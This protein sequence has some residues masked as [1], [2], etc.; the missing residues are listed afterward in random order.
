VIHVADIHVPFLKQHLDVP[1]AEERYEQF[2]HAIDGLVDAVRSA[3]KEQR[4]VTVAVVVGDVLDCRHTANAATVALVHR[5]IEGLARSVPVYVTAGNHDLLLDHDGREGQEDDLLGV[6]LAPL[7]RRLPVAYLDAT[8]VYGT[9]G[10]G[11]VFGLLHIRDAMEPGNCSGDTRDAADIPFHAICE[12]GGGR[13]EDTRIFLFHGRVSGYR[14]TPSVGG[15]GSEPA[16][17]VPNVVMAAKRCGYH[18]CL[19]GDVHT[20]QLHNCRHAAP[21]EGTVAGAG[22]ATK[23][24]VCAGQFEFSSGEGVD[25]PWAYSGSLTQLNAGERVF[26]HG[27]LEWD[28][29]A[30]RACAYHV[31]NPFGILYASAPPLRFHNLTTPVAEAGASEPLGVRETQDISWMPT[32]VAIRAVGGADPSTL[33]EE[34]KRSL[35]RMVV[36]K[37]SRSVVVANNGEGG[38]GGGGGSDDPSGNAA[39]SAAV[40]LSTSLTARPPSSTVVDLSVFG[41]AD[42]W[43]DFARER[44]RGTPDESSSSV[45]DWSEWLHTPERLRVPF[46][47][48]QPE[49]GLLTLPPSIVSKV[50]ERNAKIAK[51][52]ADLAERRGS[53][54]GGDGRHHFFSLERLRWSWLLC[55]GPDN[56]FDFTAAHRRVA[57]LAAPNGYGKSSMLEILCIALY[58]QPMASRGGKTSLTDALTRDGSPPATKAGRTS[59]CSVDITIPSSSSSREREEESFRVTRTFS[60]GP[61]GKKLTSTARVSKI[62]PP[63][64]VTLITV[65][66]GTSAVNAWVAANLG[67]LQGF[68]LCALLSQNSDADFFAMRP[69]EQ[70]GLLDD[71]LALD[72]TRTMTEVLK[73]ARLAHGAV[74]DALDTVLESQERT[75]RQAVDRE[76]PRGSSTA[77]LESHE[78]DVDR[79]IE[80]L[81]RERQETA[82]AFV[83]VRASIAEKQNLVDT[84]GRRVA[85]LR[86]VY[87]PCAISEEEEEEEEPSFEEKDEAVARSYLRRSA[88]WNA[89]DDATFRSWKEQVE[90]AMTSDGRRSVRVEDVLEEMWTALEKRRNEAT[91]AEVRCVS[92]PSQRDA[93]DEDDSSSTIRD[94]EDRLA[95]LV[96][97]RGEEEDEGEEEGEKRTDRDGVERLLSAAKGAVAEKKRAKGVLR[98]AEESRERVVRDLGVY[99]VIGGGGEVERFFGLEDAERTWSATRKARLQWRKRRDELC[100]TFPASGYVESDDEQG[101]KVKKKR[102]EAARA[103]V[104]VAREYLFVQKT[105]RQLEEKLAKDGRSEEKEDGG[106]YDDSCW[107]CNARREVAADTAKMKFVRERL[108]EVDEEAERLRHVLGG[109]EVDVERLIS[110][111]ETWLSEWLS[112]ADKDV[113]EEWRRKEMCAAQWMLK[114]TEDAVRSAAEALEAV[115]VRATETRATFEAAE[116]EVEAREVRHEIRALKR[117]L[118]VHRDRA[119]HAELE[120]AAARAREMC[121]DFRAFRDRAM[122]RF[123][124]PSHEE[125]DAA[126]CDA[127]RRLE[128]WVAWATRRLRGLEEE[129]ATLRRSEA[130]YHEENDAA[131]VTLSRA[132]VARDAYTEWRASRAHWKNARDG[133]EARKKGI[134]R[135]AAVMDGFTAWVYRHRALPAIEAEVDSLLATMNLGSVPFRGHIA[136][137]D[138]GDLGWTLGGAPIA[139]CSG[140]QRFVVSLAMRVALCQLG[141]CS[142]R[143]SQLVI[144]EGFAALDSRNIASVPEFLHEAILDAGRYVSVL[145]VSHLD[146]VRDAADVAARI[147]TT[148][149]GYSLLRFGGAF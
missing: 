129:I 76:M 97:E 90:N 68:L 28:L 110:A 126:G 123:S 128:L 47:P 69:A 109:P 116:A 60:L 133:W 41:R 149:G 6:L 93:Y 86:S 39:S 63:G 139:K 98:E 114:E 119:R 7:A 144:D 85:S 15:G 105:R 16:A 143:C 64:R 43:V 112:L 49:D 54:S 38:G 62:V 121:R 87:C 42:A 106:P 37:A 72:V 20:M 59:T 111:T 125:D 55:Y 19:L 51:K 52:C 108:A 95:E 14:S 132:S 80:E 82:A 88:A 99:T 48:S 79:V 101:Q 30:R 10:S 12:T 25:I 75:A 13:K 78:L 103:L 24:V 141:A 83:G 36:H 17:A 26:P 44:V 140:M 8:G 56:H 107:A 100:R 77:A 124:S 147:T 81:R 33:V 136:Q 137:E 1:A 65:K 31:A 2:V 32:R 145:L 113:E 67:T 134:E 61:G 21:P 3:P 29:T 131:L 34:L 102:D 104:T 120:E 4:D 22:F 9:P 46:P 96:A 91:R 73:E 57:L 122:A 40:N 74:L 66:D 127:V 18:L 84:L 142:V 11:A 89:D 35:P 138:G 53:G 135:L 50:Q 130:K 92:F 117:A 148:T 146:G 45:A 118:A 70:K 23:A 71:A 94:K 5:L 27:F 115:S 58:G